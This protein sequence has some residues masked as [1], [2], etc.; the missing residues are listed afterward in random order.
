MLQFDVRT[1]LLYGKL[2]EEV[3][4]KQPPGFETLGNANS[5]F[6]LIKSLYGL[7]QAP[8]CWNGVIDD[9]LLKAGLTKSTSDACLYIRRR[10]ED[11]TVVLLHV[12]DGLVASSRKEEAQAIMAHLKEKFKLTIMTPDRYLGL[13]IHRNRDWDLGAR[14]DPVTLHRRHT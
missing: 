14:D 1:A 5:G 2:E 13:N 4:M 3:F 9:Y 6:K 12:D 10:G 11:L 7:K 8:K